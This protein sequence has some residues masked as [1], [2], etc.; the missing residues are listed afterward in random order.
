MAEETQ[1]QAFKS[2]DFKTLFQHAQFSYSIVFPV[3][4]VQPVS[5]SWV[6]VRI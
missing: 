4:G 3:D 2:E 1:A 6:G 5:P